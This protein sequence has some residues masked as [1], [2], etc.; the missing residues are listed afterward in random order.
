M[1]IVVSH[2]R[3]AYRLTLNGICIVCVCVSVCNSSF[4]YFIESSQATAAAQ[5]DDELETAKGNEKAK[6]YDE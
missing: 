1:Q 4:C 5:N 6:I 2:N 3:I